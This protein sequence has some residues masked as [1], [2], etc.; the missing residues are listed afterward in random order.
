MSDIAKLAKRLRDEDYYKTDLHDAAADALEAQEAELRSFRNQR[1]ESGMTHQ[2][3]VG[4]W[5]KTRGG[6]DALIYDVNFKGVDGYTIRGKIKFDIY[7]VFSGWRSDGAFRPSGT[8]DPRDLMPPVEREEFWGNVYVGYI[9]SWP[10]SQIAEKR[11]DPD[12]I[13]LIHIVIEGDDFTVEK[14]MR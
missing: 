9:R 8:E 13:G 12:R 1:W 3:E 2:F 5:Y 14:V 10:S 6:H 11:A 7:D 4:K